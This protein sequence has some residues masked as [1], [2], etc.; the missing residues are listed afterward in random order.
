MAKKLNEADVA[1]FLSKNQDFARQWFTENVD[2]ETLFE[3]NEQKNSQAVQKDPNMPHTSVLSRKR[4]SF[5]P[6]KLDEY[7]ERSGSRN[8]LSKSSN[9]LFQVE[10]SMLMDLIRDIANELDVDI[11]CHKIL[12]NVSLLTKSDRGSLF[13]VRNVK[14]RRYLV[15]KLFD[16][17][18]ETKLEDALHNEDNCIE[19]PFGKGIVG[20]VAQTKKYINI[21][22]AYKVCV[23]V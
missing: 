23:G 16:V 1:T 8:K 12:I 5:T 18:N 11:L 6:N 13:L 17:T 21:Q 10:K 9:S 15:S 20:T 14:G 4:H 7:L 22:D 3:W 19:I 2:T